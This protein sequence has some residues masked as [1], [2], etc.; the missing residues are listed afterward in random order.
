MF[1]N[2]INVNGTVFDFPEILGS[3]FLIFPQVHS[4]SKERVKGSRSAS[5]LCR[6]HLVELQLQ[7]F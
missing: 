4:Q 5:R 6:M 3:S 2:I 1:T 7:E